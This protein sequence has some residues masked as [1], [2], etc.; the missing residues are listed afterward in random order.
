MQNYCN[1]MKWQSKPLMNYFSPF[2]CLYNYILAETSYL[3]N[4]IVELLDGGDH[5]NRR[6]AEG[7]APMM[8]RHKDGAASGLGHTLCGNGHREHAGRGLIQALIMKTLLHYL[9]NSLRIS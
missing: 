5:R 4:F 6:H 7:H 8:V 1:L 9:P 3:C 2:A